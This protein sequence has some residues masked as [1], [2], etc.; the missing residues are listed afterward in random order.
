[1][2]LT[3]VL[4]SR[5]SVTGVHYLCIASMLTRCI[6]PFGNFPEHQHE[7]ELGNKENQTKVLQPNDTRRSCE[8]H[9]VNSQT[10]KGDIDATGIKQKFGPTKDIRGS[11]WEGEISSKKEKPRKC[12]KIAE[13]YRP[14]RHWR[15][16]IITR[17]VPEQ[18]KDFLGD[19][20]NSRA[21]QQ[22]NNNTVIHGYRK[23]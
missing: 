15:Q 2:G 7:K 20:G 9:E 21:T 23:I 11:P 12:Q 10:L 17:K 6:R 18:Q 4:I 16:G 5:G 22:N 19:D 3:E 13:V 1:M 8:S 14:I